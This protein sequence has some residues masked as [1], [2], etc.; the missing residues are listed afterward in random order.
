MTK[1]CATCGSS[2]CGNPGFCA[3]RRKADA[4]KRPPHDPHIHQLLKLMEPDISLDHAWKVINAPRNRPTPQVTVEAIVLSV[5]E[6]G[7]G[8][9]KDPSN[10]DRLKRCDTAAKAEINRRIEK[11]ETKL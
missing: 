6:R 9:L 5:Q 8:A 2:P 7:I 1:W 4:E 11:W 3:L 10:I